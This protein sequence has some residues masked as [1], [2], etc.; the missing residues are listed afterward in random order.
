MDLCRLI[1]ALS[2]VNG[3]DHCRDGTELLLGT[4]ILTYL[5]FHTCKVLRC[6]SS[7]SFWV[8]SSLS[9]NASLLVAKF[10]LLFSFISLPQ[11]ILDKRCFWCLWPFFD[12]D[13]GRA[14]SIALWTIHKKYLV[15][16]NKVN[17]SLSIQVTHL[18]CM[19]V[20]VG[21]CSDNHI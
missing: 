2:L 7:R 10:A 19:G 12:N 18:C 9:W 3:A 17:L 20:C 16:L 11:L 1:H 6:W 8:S 15:H 4:E 21:L 14:L 5:Q 13:E